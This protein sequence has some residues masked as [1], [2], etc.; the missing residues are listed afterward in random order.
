MEL[1]S[2]VLAVDPHTRVIILADTLFGRNCGIDGARTRA[3]IRMSA[4]D[5]VWPRRRGASHKRWYGCEEFGI[6]RPNQP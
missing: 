4:N 2:E 5:R 3:A 6:E 1:A